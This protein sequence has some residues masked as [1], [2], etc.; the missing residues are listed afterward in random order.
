MAVPDRSN[1]AAVDH[2]HD[3]VRGR[4]G[5]ISRRRGRAPSVVRAERALDRRGQ[6]SSLG[7]RD[8][9]PPTVG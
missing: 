8:L 3:T 7:R 6:E 1:V 4:P 9:D 2:D 5:T